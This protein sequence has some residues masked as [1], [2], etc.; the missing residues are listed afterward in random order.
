MKVNVLNRD[1]PI[2]LLLLAVSQI[3]QHLQMAVAKVYR[4]FHISFVLAHSWAAGS[5]HPCQHFAWLWTAHSVGGCI[6]FWSSRKIDCLNNLFN[7]KQGLFLSVNGWDCYSK[8]VNTLRKRFL[9]RP[10]RTRNRSLF[11]GEICEIKHQKT[12]FLLFFFFNEDVIDFPAWHIWFC[13]R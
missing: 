8:Y 4:L 5:W 1:A 9:Q 7:V 13:C 11:E 2:Y 6:D 3:R 10:T 12:I